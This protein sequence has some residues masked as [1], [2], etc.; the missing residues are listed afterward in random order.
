MNLQRTLEIL[1]IIIILAKLKAQLQLW[2]MLLWD[3]C[4][5]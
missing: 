4:V 5:S 3:I 2:M 1:Q